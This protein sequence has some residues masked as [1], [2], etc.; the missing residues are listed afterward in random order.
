MI[1]PSEIAER[2][3]ASVRAR[4]IEAFMALF[5]VDAT[6]T[7]PDGR[8][9]SGLADIRKMESETFEKG[10][11][12]PTPTAIVYSQDAIAVQIDVRVSSG[13]V[14]KMANF[15]VLD[16]AGLIKTLSVYRQQSPGS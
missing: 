3:F 12:H 5:A 2:Y 7:L 1:N 10:A 15:Y 16:S 4:D 9:I 13:A 14:L 6:L 8:M 11:P